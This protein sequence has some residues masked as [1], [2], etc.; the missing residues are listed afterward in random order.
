MFDL[1]LQK[2]F[3][4]NTVAQWSIALAIV[5]GSIIVGK[6]I[7]WVLSR[8]VKSFTRKTKTKLD[9]I[10]VDTI[11]EPIVFALVLW[12]IWFGL[13][14]LYLSTVAVLW[15]N[16]IY[17]VLIVFTI[18]WFINR[19]FDALI[20]EYIVPKV[21]KS[22]STF[23]NILLPVVR[24]GTRFAIWTLALVIALNN[25]GYNVSALLA[26]LGVGGLALALA[27]QDTVSNLFGGFTILLDKPFRIGDRIII[28]G[29]D[30]FVREIGIRSTRIETLN[31][32]MITIPNKTFSSS[33]IENISSEPARKVVMK[34]GL[35]YTTPPEKMTLALDLLQKISTENTSVEDTVVTS[36]T[37]FG[38]FSLGITYIYYIKKS[39][40]IFT[41]QNA[42]NLAILKTFNEHGLGFAFP[43]QTIYH[44][45]I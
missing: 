8:V 3:Y 10:F 19:I 16:R 26:G 33:A 25:A 14:T 28:S 23:D 21:D 44:Q 32:R 4:G 22:E 31:N 34:L 12:G 30:G 43:T 17:H 13:H 6:M 7:Y 38:D 39:E 45:K 36:F 29:I 27:A 42:I 15:I 18:A 35:E 11:E 24:K 5:V 37:D 41:T 40:D 9:Y 20:G 1:F 2:E